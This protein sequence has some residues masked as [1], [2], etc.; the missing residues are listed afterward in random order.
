MSVATAS[1]G[2]PLPFYFG[3]SQ[4]LFGIYHPPERLPRRAT[5]VVLCYPAGHE[6]LRVQRAFRNL[7]AAIVRLGFP[8]LRFDYRGTGDSLGDGSTA[9]LDGWRADLRLAIEEVKRRS[10]ANRVAVAGLRLG[11]SIAWIESLDRSDVDMLV[12]WDPVVHGARYLSQLG[13]LQAAWLAE[14]GRHGDA[15]AEAAAGRLLGFDMPP[16]LQQQ[17]RSLDISATDLPSTAKV[18]AILAADLPEEVTWRERLRARFGP[19]SCGVFPTV[20]WTDPA[21]IH[22]AVY[23]Q[24]AQQL[25]AAILDK[26]AG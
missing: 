21:S 4:S 16:G 5:A 25:I 22:I 2:Q 26:V 9:T 1:A 24:A 10:G 15:S 11:A 14:P 18:F 20:N 12:L 3:P 8:V 13:D 6:A 17:I 23:P 19:N 7:A